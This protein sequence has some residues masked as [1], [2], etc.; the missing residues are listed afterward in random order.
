MLEVIKQKK[1]EEEA[2][3]PLE[4]WEIDWLNEQK[5]YEQSC[6]DEQSQTIHQEVEYCLL[7]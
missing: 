3:R 5:R 2:K 7:E 1:A 4:D 6:E